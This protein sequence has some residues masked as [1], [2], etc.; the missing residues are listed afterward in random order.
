MENRRK[1]YL[2]KA[3]EKEFLLKL[4]DPSIYDRIQQLKVG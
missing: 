4:F 1:F 2:L 3:K